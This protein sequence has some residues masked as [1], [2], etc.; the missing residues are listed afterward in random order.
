MPQYTVRKTF[1]LYHARYEKR[2][3]NHSLFVVKKGE[4]VWPIKSRLARNLGR[5]EAPLDCS[6]HNKTR[7]KM[8]VTMKIDWCKLAKLGR[9]K[10]K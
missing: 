9:E 4:N 8:E 5:E 1:I 6:Y 2:P 10:L 7:K 3:E